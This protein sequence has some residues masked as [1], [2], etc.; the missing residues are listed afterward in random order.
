MAKP[1]R[2]SLGRRV[3]ALD[4]GRAVI[5][6]A[7]AAKRLKTHGPIIT[8]RVQAGHFTDLNE[9]FGVGGILESEVQAEERRMQDGELGDATPTERLA[10]GKFN[11]ARADVAKQF[12]KHRN[13]IEPL[14]VAQD[15]HDTAQAITELVC[16][17]LE[18]WTPDF[19]ANLSSIGHKSFATDI[20]IASNEIKRA[21]AEAVEAPEEQILAAEREVLISSPTPPVSESMVE[22]QLA[23]QLLKTAIV[24]TEVLIEQ[25]KLAR[26]ESVEFKLRAAASRL[27]GDIG[28]L[29]ARLMSN[30]ATD[31]RGDLR[32]Q[33]RAFIL[34]LQSLIGKA[35][36]DLDEPSA[37]A[38]QKGL[39]PPSDLTVSEWADRYRILSAVAS[40]E[41]GIWR[42]DKTPYLRYPIDIMGGI[43]S[44]V[45][46]VTLMFSAQSGK[47]EALI[48]FSAYTACQ[49]NG[50]PQL[51]VQPTDK[52]A[53]Q[54]ATTRLTEIEKIPAV[55]EKLQSDEVDAKGKASRRGSQ[56][57]GAMHKVFTD[58]SLTVVSAGSPANLASKPVR[59][60][61]IDESDRMET[62]KEGDP[63]KLAERRTNS[64]AHSKMIVIT[65]TST[66]KEQSRVERSFEAG[67]Q[68]H[69][70]VPCH[71]CGEKH[72]LD[73]ENIHIEELDKSSDANDIDRASREAY[74]SCP[75]CGSVWDEAQR[76][77]AVSAGEWIAHNPE[78]KDHFSFHA[79]VLVSPFVPLSEVVKEYLDSRGNAEREM[80]FVN[81]MLAQAYSDVD[82]EID[83]D[84][85]IARMQ[86]SDPEMSLDMVP[87]DV[88]L[89]TT[90]TDVQAD[91]LETLFLGHKQDGSVVFLQHVVHY[92]DPSNSND[93]CYN[94]LD[95][96]LQTKFQHALGGKIRVERSAFD[97]GYQGT[98]VSE[99]CNRRPSRYFPIKGVAGEH[100]PIWQKSKSTDKKNAR[101][102]IVGTH[103][104]KSKLMRLLANRTDG[105]VVATFADMELH[106][107]L[108]AEHFAEQLLAEYPHR[109]FAKNGVQKT[110]WRRKSAGR[111]AEIL[112]TTVYAMAVR[113]SLTISN[114]DARRE[115]LTHVPDPEAKSKKGAK[116]E[117]ASMYD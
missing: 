106:S 15:A 85:I 58:G 92:G 61:L 49:P 100:R 60:L 101:L 107:P 75:H 41:P 77:E 66:I 34:E 89:I 40:A 7:E 50:G 82:S 105:G 115:K 111:K 38:F 11:K 90:G 36:K 39:T 16:S 114:W 79:N 74:Y 31:A 116:R 53:H 48:N 102:H 68:H 8:Q 47:S 43:E 2:K 20:E 97:T 54:F 56:A 99:F 12:Y 109:T 95:A 57:Q 24:Q 46:K 21:L 84:Q 9:K 13:L 29:P 93:Q 33:C 110:E 117:W 103:Q 78:I 18:K 5:T 63:I 71:D 42:T 52:A 108:G 17:E 98:A 94:E 25:G 37:R 88:L 70:Y 91:R 44:G 1:R 14:I 69:F 62:T 72:V 81:T 10:Q 23:L 59:A 65:S 3:K 104:G 67:S 28:N 30:T 83:E 6:K 73:F 27:M 87:E 86:E 55:A 19:L 76:H 80:T 96:L 64:F 26:R 112:D 113:S 32:P 45:R 35:A 22:D 51:M 4:D